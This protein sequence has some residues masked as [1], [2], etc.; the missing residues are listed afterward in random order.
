MCFSSVGQE[1]AGGAPQ[2]R[3]MA[4]GWSLVSERARRGDSLVSTNVGIV[5]PSSP[6]PRSDESARGDDHPGA[7]APG[8]GLIRELLL[9]VSDALYEEGEAPKC[10]VS[11]SARGYTTSPTPCLLSTMG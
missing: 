6:P 2:V 7:L 1:D 11:L 5:L 8:L 10:L 3:R 9:Q 4:T